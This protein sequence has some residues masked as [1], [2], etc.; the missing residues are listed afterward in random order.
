VNDGV[1]DSNMAT[2]NVT[3]N[4]APP[5]P[6]P[7]SGGGGGGFGPLALLGLLLLGLSAH[8]RRPRVIN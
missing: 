2:V 1:A 3:I 6:P 8:V 7:P 5:P 4:A